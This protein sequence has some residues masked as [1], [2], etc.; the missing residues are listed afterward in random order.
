MLRRLTVYFWAVSLW[1]VPRRAL[2][3]HHVSQRVFRSVMR[4]PGTLLLLA[5]RFT[6]HPKFVFWHE[7]M[8]PFHQLPCRI[9]P[10]LLELSTWQFPIRLYWLLLLLSVH[11]ISGTIRA[12][13]CRCASMCDQCIS[14]P[15]HPSPPL[16]SLFEYLD[17][18]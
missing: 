15:L 3:W 18:W 14:P 6:M 5:S 4:W 13:V 12:R 17:N 7:Y 11:S 16:F 9:N 8:R 2:S 10:K 1:Y